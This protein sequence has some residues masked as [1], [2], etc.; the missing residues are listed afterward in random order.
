MWLAAALFKLV[1]KTLTTTTVEITT[2]LKC[3]HYQA[4][5]V[6]PFTAATSS[7]GSSNSNNTAATAATAVAAAAVTM[8]AAVGNVKYS[9]TLPCRQM[10]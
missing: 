8:A 6:G 2:M 5:K 9:L 10:K 7:N 3:H 1:C 4:T